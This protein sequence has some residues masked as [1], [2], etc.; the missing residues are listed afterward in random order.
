M[1]EPEFIT[2]YAELVVGLLS[3]PTTED[4]AET[5]RDGQVL[6]RELFPDT[7]STSFGFHESEPNDFDVSD[8]GG[9][10]VKV[11]PSYQERG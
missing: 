11:E 3:Y 4:V 6:Y 8:V 1:N 9:T 5:Y 7:E 10:D 2:A